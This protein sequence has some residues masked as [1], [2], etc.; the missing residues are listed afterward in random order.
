MLDNIKQFPWMRI[1]TWA[2]VLGI[3]VSL[4]TDWGNWDHFVPNAL[5]RIL[6][7]AAGGVVG[8]IMNIFTGFYIGMATNVIESMGLFRFSS[9]TPKKIEN[10]FIFMLALVGAIIGALVI[11]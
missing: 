7:V 3:G 9:E 1:M 5:W 11:G 4:F 8:W 6:I 2:L 10:G